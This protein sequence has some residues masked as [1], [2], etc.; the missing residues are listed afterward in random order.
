MA[1]SESQVPLGLIEGTVKCVVFPFS[2]VRKVGPFESPET[3]VLYKKED[4]DE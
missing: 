2:C 3:R 1:S 4:F